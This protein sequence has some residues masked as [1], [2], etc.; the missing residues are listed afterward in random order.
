V[1]ETYDGYDMRRLTLELSIPHLTQVNQHQ[2]ALQR[3]DYLIDNYEN[4]EMQKNL[5]FQ[6]G[7]IYK[8]GLGNASEAERVFIRFLELYPTHDLALMAEAEL[9]TSGYSGGGGAVSSAEAVDQ[10]RMRLASQAYPNPFSSEVA[11]AY[12]LPWTTRVTVTIYD[13]SGRLIRTLVDEV[14]QA[15]YYT[16]SWRGDDVHGTRLPTGVYFASIVSEKSKSTSKLLLV[17]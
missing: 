14:K 5:L 4:E 9:T 12:E 2:L 15:G 16:V 6:K 13:A 11:I 7:M 8:Y 3:C 1:A 10:P 17:R